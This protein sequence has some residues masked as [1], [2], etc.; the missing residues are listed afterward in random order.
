MYRHL[1]HFTDDHRIALTDGYHALMQSLEAGTGVQ[2][3]SM[4]KLT[5]VMQA[6]LAEQKSLQPFWEQIRTNPERPCHLHLMCKEK[7]L[8]NLPW[9]LAID[10]QRDLPIQLSKGPA[11][12]AAFP[13]YRP[14]AGPLRIL[15]VISSPDDLD[16]D[17]RLS[18]EQEEE[19]ILKALSPLLIA[20]AA[21][22]HFAE[23]G[24]LET[25]RQKL[26]LQRYAIL[27]FSGHGIY[28]NDTGY[29][30]MEDPAT[31]R[32]AEVKA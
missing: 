22:V 16:Y 24:S 28:K 9:Q 6:L 13:I 32:S 12:D 29:L 23:D 25:L 3:Q 17:R 18:Y 31:L 5:A 14:Q 21:Q 27:Y 10:P 15:V 8:L 11:T 20:G 1:L 19:M 26:Q 2:K 4:D 30:L 7:E